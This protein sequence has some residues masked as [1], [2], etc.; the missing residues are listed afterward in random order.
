MAFWKGF[1]VVLADAHDLA[2]GPHLRA[3]AV[4]RPSYF[5]KAQRANFTTT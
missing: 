3:Q 2:H 1:L 4:F 5:S